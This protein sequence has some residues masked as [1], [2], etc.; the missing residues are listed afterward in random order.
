MNKRP[1]SA[2]LLEKVYFASSLFTY[3]C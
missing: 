3:N 1:A 2:A